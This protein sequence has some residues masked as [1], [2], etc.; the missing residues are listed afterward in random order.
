MSSD[1]KIPKKS[2][3]KTVSQNF[4]P[5]PLV[6]NLTLLSNLANDEAVTLLSG[7]ALVET[8]LFGE[9]EVSSEEEVAI[10]IIVLSDEDVPMQSEGEDNVR[11]LQTD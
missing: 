4:E 3:R 6:D 5:P 1:F 11:A 7:T 10:P 2:P 8:E 9:Q